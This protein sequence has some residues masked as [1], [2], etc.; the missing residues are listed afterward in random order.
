MWLGLSDPI[1]GYEE[2]VQPKPRS[3]TARVTAKCCVRAIAQGQEVN[4]PIR[5]EHSGSSVPD[6]DLQ[7]LP[8][9]PHRDRDVGLRR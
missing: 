7:S 8:N 3:G 2:S 1:V 9:S 5:V 4:W 6:L